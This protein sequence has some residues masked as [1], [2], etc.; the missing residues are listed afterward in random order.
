M[1]TRD[2]FA[3]ANLL[4]ILAICNVLR[5]RAGFLHNAATT[6]RRRAQLL[7]YVTTCVRVC[8]CVCDPVIDKAPVLVGSAAG[9]ANP[10]VPG[11]V[12]WRGRASE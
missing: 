10:A 2:V 9:T 8:V 5:E 3:I 1:L 11:R 7:G 6:V 4:V 12:R